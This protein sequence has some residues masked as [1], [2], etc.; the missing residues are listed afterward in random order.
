MLNVTQFTPLLFPLYLKTKFC[1]DVHLAGG[2]EIGMQLH[3]SYMKWNVFCLCICAY[4]KLQVTDEKCGRGKANGYF[5][6][7]N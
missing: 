5:L 7:P 1:T 2:H 4:K 3:A 6:T